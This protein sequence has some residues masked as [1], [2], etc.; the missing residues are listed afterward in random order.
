MKPQDKNI[1]DLTVLNIAYWSISIFL[2][3]TM[4]I[5]L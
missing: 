4:L 2:I 5:V 3:L 1:N